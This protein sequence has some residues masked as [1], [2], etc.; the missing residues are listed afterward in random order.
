MFLTRL[1]FGSKALITGN[2]T[3]I[4]LPDNRPLSTLFDT[5]SSVR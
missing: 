5:R 4:D 3:H 2:V 1:G